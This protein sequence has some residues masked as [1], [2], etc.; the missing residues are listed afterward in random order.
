M[1]SVNKHKLELGIS[2]EIP[3]TVFIINKNGRN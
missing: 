1:Y 3:L 2:Q